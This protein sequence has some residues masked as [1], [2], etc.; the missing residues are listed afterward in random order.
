MLSQQPDVTVIEV[1]DYIAHPKPNGYMSFHMIIE[2]PVLLSDR[3]ERVPVE[4]Q[5]RTIAM[6]L[7]ASLEHKIYNKYERAVPPR[8]LNELTDA[9]EAA[10]NLDV[11]MQRLHKRRCR[12]HRRAGRP[13]CSPGPAAAEHDRRLAARHRTI[14]MNQSTTQTLDSAPPGGVTGRGSK[15]FRERVPVRTVPPSVEYRTQRPTQSGPN[16]IGA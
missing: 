14:S 9:A 12:P 1:E 16:P 10:H 11:K 4:V 13:R 7:W 8:L 5:I 6:D 15:E 3:V 2:I